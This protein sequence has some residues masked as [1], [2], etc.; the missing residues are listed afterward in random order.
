MHI[1]KTFPGRVLNLRTLL[2]V[3]AVLTVARVW[4]E[5]PAINAPAQAQIPDSAAQRNQ[6]IV[7]VQRT[8]SLLAEML[9][10]LRDG[11]IKV[12]IVDADNTPKEPVRKKSG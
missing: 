12:R 8:N 9:A 6:L 5:G 2:W 11:S 10:E 1:A 3:V 4:F 7:E